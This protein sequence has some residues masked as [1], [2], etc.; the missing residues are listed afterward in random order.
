MKPREIRHRSEI[1][2]KIFCLVFPMSFSASCRAATHIAPLCGVA[3]LGA[4]GLSVAL[5]VVDGGL[6]PHRLAD[7]V[8]VCARLED[9]L[10]YRLGRPL[11]S[12]EEFV[13][14]ALDFEATL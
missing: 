13:D 14:A 5:V 9:V 10:G 1:A 3:V 11:F 12:G 6:R 7:S 2:N 8:D 4:S